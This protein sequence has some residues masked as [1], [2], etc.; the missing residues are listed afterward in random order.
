MKPFALLILLTTGDIHVV[1]TPS[2][3][4]CWLDRALLYAKSYEIAV[5]TRMRS[6]LITEHGQV[7]QPGFSFACMRVCEEEEACS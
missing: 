3:Q 6:Q 5:A 4:Q 2:E 1:M 7:V